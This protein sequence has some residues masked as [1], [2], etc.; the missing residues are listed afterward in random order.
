MS[1]FLCRHYRSSAFFQTTIGYASYIRY[2]DQ[3]L[4]CAKYITSYWKM[5]VGVFTRRWPA[6]C[7]GCRLRSSPVSSC[8]FRAVSALLSRIRLQFFSTSYV[9]FETTPSPAK[10]KD[11]IRLIRAKFKETYSKGRILVNQNIYFVIYLIMGEECGT[12]GREKR[13]IQGFGV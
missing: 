4:F 10:Q 13:C 3:L 9:C 12:Y 5:E 6:G 2:E 1:V 7:A 11:V 8:G